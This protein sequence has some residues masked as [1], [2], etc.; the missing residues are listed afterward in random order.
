MSTVADRS[1]PFSLSQIHDLV[2]MMMMMLLL[3]YMYVY[4]YAHIHTCIYVHMYIYPTESIW[5]F[6]VYMSKSEIGESMWEV[7]CG[8]NFLSVAI[9]FL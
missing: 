7:I 6:Y 9:E 3:I 2:M 5:C 8:G 1:C 4:I